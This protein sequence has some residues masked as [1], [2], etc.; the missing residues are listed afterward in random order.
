MDPLRIRRNI[1][2]AITN[3]Q[4]IRITVEPPTPDVPPYD[5]IV[6]PGYIGADDY[7]YYTEDVGQLYA[8][9]HHRVGMEF[10]SAAEIIP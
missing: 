3:S 1:H 8:G 10:I 6:I 9:Q 2:R 4:K 7:F 5:V